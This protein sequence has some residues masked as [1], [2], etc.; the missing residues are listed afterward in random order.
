MQFL[1]RSRVAQCHHVVEGGVPKPSYLLPL[2]VQHCVAKLN[3]IHWLLDSF[4]LNCRLLLTSSCLFFPSALFNRAHVLS[5]SFPARAIF[6]ARASLLLPL[7]VA[8]RQWPLLPLHHLC[9]F[10]AC[11]GVI[12]SFWGFNGRFTYYRWNLTISL[13]SLAPLYSVP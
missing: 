1:R 7:A 13:K 3:M 9:G 2:W 5:F 4:Q 6:L 11:Y 8:P 10:L 12:E